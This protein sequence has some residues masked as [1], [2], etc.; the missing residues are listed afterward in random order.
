MSGTRLREGLLAA[1]RI[2]PALE[3]RYRERLRA[4]TERRLTPVQR[5]SHIVGLLIALG[6]VARFVQMLVQHGTGG[7]PVA[8]VGIALGFAFSAGWVLA[9]SAVLR[10]GV[11]RFFSHGAVRM[12]LIVSFTS[13]LAGLMLWAGLERPDA[14]QG[15]RLILFGLV[16]WCAIGLP[17]LVAYLVGQGELRVRADV[18]RLELTL[19]ERG[20]SSEPRS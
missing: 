3:Q 1:E 4:L 12:L 2:T 11:N 14:A 9:E 20:E 8:V 7:R 6:L 17:F 15:V 5:G 16:F 10:S 19:A 13:L 18:L